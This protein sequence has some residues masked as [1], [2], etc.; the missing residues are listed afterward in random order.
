MVEALCLMG[1][2]GIVVGL[3]LAMAHGIVHQSGGDIDCTS[4]PGQGTRF[5]F[6][7]P[8]VED[9]VDLQPVDGVIQRGTNHAGINKGGTTALLA[10]ILIDAEARA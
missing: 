3:G 9:E 1:G 4:K 8:R 2:L 7:L 6:Y 10:A 5:R